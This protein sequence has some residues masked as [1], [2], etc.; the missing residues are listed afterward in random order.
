MPA[1]CPDVHRSLTVP[2]TDLISP[3]DPLTKPYC[4]SSPTRHSLRPV[5]SCQHT[6]AKQPN[7]LWLGI[8]SGRG[9][10]R[11]RKRPTHKVSRFA[12]V[13]IDKPSHRHTIEGISIE[14]E[15]ARQLAMGAAALHVLPRLDVPSFERVVFP[16]PDGEV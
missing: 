3:P 6:N 4:G 5:P 10:P 13:R 14:R 1:P 8:F 7:H 11:K 2:L 12:S 9:R 16:R 15:R